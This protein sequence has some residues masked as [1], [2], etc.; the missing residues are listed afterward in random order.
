[1]FEGGL[2]GAGWNGAPPTRVAGALDPSGSAARFAGGGAEAVATAAADGARLELVAENRRVALARVERSSPTLGAAPPAAATIVFGLDPR[3]GALVNATN[4]ELDASGDLRAGA[5]SRA[6]FG[7]ARIHLEFRTPFMPSA[8]GQLRGN[9]GVYIQDRYEIQVLDSFGNAPAHDECASIYRSRAPS[10]AM[11]FP[12]LQWQTYDIEF[13]AA[14]FGEDGVR[15]EPAR[16]RV[17][18]NGVRVHDDVALA[19]PTGLGEREGREPGPLTL[20]DHWNPVVFR[21][22]WVVP[23]DE[24]ASPASDLD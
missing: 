15:T 14:R 12:P 6:A 18:H 11:A 20:Q 19:G 5:T 1:V 8:R 22:V 23:I 21:N 7:S 16:L 24:P 13:T 4:G 10:I 3:T 2:P 9:S 17:L